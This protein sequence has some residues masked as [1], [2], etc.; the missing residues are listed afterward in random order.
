[1]FLGVVVMAS[2]NKYL[3]I[4]ICSVVMFIFSPTRS[5]DPLGAA[6]ISLASGILLL[7]LDLFFD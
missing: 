5:K 3:W 4:V 1:M 2:M 6:V 7:V